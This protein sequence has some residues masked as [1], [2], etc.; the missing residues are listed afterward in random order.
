MTLPADVDKA[1]KPILVIKTVDSDSEPFAGD[2][3]SLDEIPLDDVYVDEAREKFIA[4]PE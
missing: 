1:N 2:N 3:N 4:N